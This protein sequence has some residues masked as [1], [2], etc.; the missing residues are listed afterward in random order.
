MLGKYWWF[1][2]GMENCLAVSNW[3]KNLNADWWWGV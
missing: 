2:C 3:K 1:D